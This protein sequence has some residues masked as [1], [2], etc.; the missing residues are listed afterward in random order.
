MAFTLT[1]LGTDTQYTPDPKS[2]DHYDRGETLSFVSRLIAGNDL[3]VEIDPVHLYRDTQCLIDGPKTLGSEVGDR[4]ARGVLAILKAVGRGETQINMMAH[5]RGA[6]EAILVAHELERIQKICKEEPLPGKRKDLIKNSPCENTQTAMKTDSRE[7]GIA[8]QLATLDF[9]TIAKNI[10]DVKLSMFNIDPV[11]GGR[12]QGAP[13]R[14]VDGR[15][16]HVPAIVKEYEQYVY[17]NERSRCFKAIVPKESPDTHFKLNSLPGHH[18]TGSGNAKDQQGNAVPKDKGTT[19]HVQDLLILKLID[20]LQRNQVNF[21]K[22][23]ALSGS[24]DLLALVKPLIEVSGSS[25]KY[26]AVLKAQ[27]LQTYDH[28]M[29]NREAYRYFNDTSYAVLGQ[30]QG[31][32]AL[33]GQ[34]VN[35][36]IIHF[37][38]HNDTFLQ[39]IL[40]ALPGGKLLNAEHARLF[41]SNKMGLHEENLTLAGVIKQSTTHLLT[42]CKHY[43]IQKNQSV[44][45]QYSVTD[46]FLQNPIVALLEK[47]EGIELISEGLNILIEQVSQTYL[48][49][50]LVDVEERRVLFQAVRDTL[51]HFSKVAEDEENTLAISINEKLKEGL[52]N[53]LKAKQ[54]SLI[55]RSAHIFSKENT[56]YHLDK[57]LAEI[58]KLK[59]IN[60]QSLASLQEIEISLRQEAAVLK[61]KG[62]SSETV[63]QLITDHYEK[64]RTIYSQLQDSSVLEDLSLAEYVNH[65]GIAMYEALDNET[66]SE[67]ASKFREWLDVYQRLGDFIK[68]LDNFIEF[69]TKLPHEKMKEKLQEKQVLL[70]HSAARYMMEKKL[71][72]EKVNELF[73]NE[74]QELY[75]QIKGLAMGMGVINPLEIKHEQAVKALEEKDLA[76]DVQR[77]ELVNMEYKINQNE[78]QF[79]QQKCIYEQT[80]KQLEEKNQ[81]QES[82]NIKKIE[83]LQQELIEKNLELDAHRKELDNR[84][85][86]SRTKDL[87]LEGQR[88]QLKVMDETLRLKDQEIY[89]KVQHAQDL[90]GR[91]ENLLRDHRNINEARCLILIEEKLLPSTEKYLRDLWKEIKEKKSLKIN[92]SDNIANIAKVKTHV[93]RLDFSDE[94]ALKE[95]FDAVTTL[96]EKLLEPEQPSHYQRMSNF[97]QTLNEK[98]KQITKH[99]DSSWKRFVIGLSILLTGILP[100]L[101]VLGIVSAVQGK[102]FRFWQSR[103]E[104]YSKAIK[105]EQ[106][107]IANA[108]PNKQNQMGR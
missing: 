29:E 45:H 83:A 88:R 84:E 42:I 54:D 44:A 40:P 63:Q 9:S 94:V 58:G 60:D 14:W 76:L 48:Q 104:T 67:S 71:S 105:E 53:A 20:F 36:R 78:L 23:E 18:G 89:N 82:R 39:Q 103:G 17:E 19:V 6:V 4:I 11:P 96:Y 77:R 86:N 91:Y 64:F 68:L 51:N 33:I 32:K 62:S 108:Q 26:K 65:F 85:Q 43:K 35:D 99:R 81:I 2:E 72:L 46:S 22:S 3:E 92:L 49:D 52:R 28:I 34:R 55:Q 5:S 70:I 75:K 13:V 66:A 97:F 10:Q 79:Q 24:A 27:Y 59:D 73:G 21:K 30:E 102:S 61:E 69:N 106:E 38:A 31:F 95:K 57:L 107:T 41:L 101:A 7:G 56:F 90:Q 50:Q 16:Y 100:G 25:K 47:E 15:F 80:I 37:Q 93:N 8:D 1:L 74:N 98:N 87:Q 12:F